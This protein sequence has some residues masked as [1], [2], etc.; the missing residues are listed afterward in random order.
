MIDVWDESIC[1]VAVGDKEGF[2]KHIL[3]LLEDQSQREIWSNKG[4]KTVKKYDWNS[5]AEKELNLIL[6][7]H[8]S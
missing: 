8:E 4:L 6:G 1:T 7:K 5:I 3:T 2:A